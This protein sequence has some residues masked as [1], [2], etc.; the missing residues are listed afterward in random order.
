MTV[1]FLTQPMQTQWRFEIS[2]NRGLTP[3]GC[4]FSAPSEADLWPRTVEKN[5][6]SPA[7]TADE[8]RVPFAV[9]IASRYGI[10]AA[11]IAKGYLLDGTKTARAIAQRNIYCASWKR[12]I[13]VS[14]II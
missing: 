14:V 8:I 10:A 11:I 2:E 9:Q 12:H 13:R 4:P 5:D 7:N 1:A 3:S 6:R